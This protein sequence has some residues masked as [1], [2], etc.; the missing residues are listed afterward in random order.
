MPA[1]EK[2]LS[3]NI[4]IDNKGKCYLRL[5]FGVSLNGNFNR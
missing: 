1:K 5:T 4:Y 2:G 3:R